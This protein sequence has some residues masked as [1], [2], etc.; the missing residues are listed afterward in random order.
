MSTYA[1][2]LSLR[3]CFL[4]I[5][6]FFAKKQKKKK[7]NVFSPLYYLFLCLSICLF[8]VRPIIKES[9]FFIKA[10][11]EQKHKIYLTHKI[12]KQ[13]GHPSKL[14]SVHFFISF[15]FL[16]FRGGGQKLVMRG[17]GSCKS[18]QVRTRG[19]GAGGGGG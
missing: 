1:V 3:L 5:R 10:C 7:T 6:Y 18:V 12:V 4:K 13:F 19:E 15:G 9:P 17:W 8:Y 16:Y 2:I 14:H 11:F